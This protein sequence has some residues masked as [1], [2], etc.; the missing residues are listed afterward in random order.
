MTNFDDDYEG[1]NWYGLMYAAITFAVNSPDASTQNA[2][3]L[4]MPDGNGLPETLSC[5]GFPLGIESKR[6][7]W[8]RPVK[9]SYV[10][11]AERNAIYAAAREGIKTEGLTL[12]AVW[13]SCADCA[14][15]IIQSG[16]SRL[17]RYAGTAHTRWDESIAIADTMFEEAGIEVI[18]LT[19]PILGTPILLRNGSPWT[20]DGVLDPATPL[21]Y[22]K[23]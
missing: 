14:R 7:R 12:V 1:P 22:S 23:G 21:I 11:H 18:T 16:I 6:E 13:A 2:A 8:E 5:N 20:P 4:T 19:Q 15:A 3:M 10:E 9:Y 17:V